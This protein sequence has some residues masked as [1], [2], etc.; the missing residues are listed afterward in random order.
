MAIKAKQVF[1]TLIPNSFESGSN[2]T[3][4]GDG[5]LLTFVVLVMKLE[6]SEFPFVFNALTC[7]NE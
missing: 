6:K 1:P 3:C 2:V 7:G 5:T 4:N